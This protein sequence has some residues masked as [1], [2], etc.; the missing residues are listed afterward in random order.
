M[1][2][3][4]YDIYINGVLKK[5]G[6]SFNYPVS[7]VSKISFYTAN[8]TSGVMYVDNVTISS[9]G[10]LES[11]NYGS[12]YNATGNP[13]G[14]GEGYSGLVNSW[15]TYVS[16]ASDLVAALSNA[17]SGNVIYVDDNADLEVNSYL[18]LQLKA[19]VTLASGRGKMI[20]GTLSQGARLHITPD[21]AG[22]VNKSIITVIGEGARVTGLRLDGG[23]S[24]R[25][26]L[27]TRYLPWT[28]CVYAWGYNTTEVDN[29]DITGNRWGGV[30]INDGYVHHNNI[31]DNPYWELGYSIVQDGS[32]TTGGILIEGNLFD[33]NRHDIAST[34]KNTSRY[35]ARYNTTLRFDYGHAYD[36]HRNTACNCA[37]DWVKIHHNTFKDTGNQNNHAIRIR[38]IPVTSTNIF[39]NWFYNPSW[40]VDIVQSNVSQASAN[41]IVGTNKYG[42]TNIQY[43]TGKFSTDIND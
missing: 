32:N 24:T 7:S 21:P 31:H 22:G 10:E 36:M 18:P 30:A 27:I 6:L 35:E 39:N 42:T 40:S 3:H 1:P 33:N 38:G 14:G 20:N 17:M 15:T 26:D 5:S 25:G 12:T 9:E 29:N 13:I 41:F 2:L 16:T 8:T 4:Q 11:A 37:G 23:D 34:G 43:L 28:N 19:G